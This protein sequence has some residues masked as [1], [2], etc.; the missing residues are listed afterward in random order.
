MVFTSSPG[1]ESALDNSPV[2]VINA[3]LTDWKNFPL[4]PNA[5]A[6]IT[7]P[8]MSQQADGLFRHRQ[9]AE[10]LAAWPL[11]HIWI[12]SSISVYGDP[13][14]VIDETADASAGASAAVEA[15][16]S[17]LTNATI[18]RLGG[19]FGPHRHPGRFLSGKHG[20]AK[21]LAPVNMLHLSDAVNAIDFLMDQPHPSTVY[22]VVHPDHPSR[23]EFYTKAIELGSFEPVQ[24]NTSDQGTGKVVSSS[25]IQAAGFHFLFDQLAKY[26]EEL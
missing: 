25:R 21:P 14:A 9:L 18:V 11:K 6:V 24:F 15:E 8:P 23:E 2:E 10:T 5:H 20:V 26:L 4:P 17:A 16:Y 1:R 3:P 12:T 19:L 13:P 22:N 7:W